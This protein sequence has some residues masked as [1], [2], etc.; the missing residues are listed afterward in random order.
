MNEHII[1]GQS[2]TK[3]RIAVNLEGGTVWFVEESRLK[4]VLRQCDFL[5]RWVTLQLRKECSLAY[6]QD[7]K[8]LQEIASGI[9][10]VAC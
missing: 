3:L 6:Q 1:N 4:E 8:E 5:D 10:N 9:R 7:L 2:W